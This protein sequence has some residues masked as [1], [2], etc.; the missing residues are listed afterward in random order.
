MLLPG[1]FAPF[2]HVASSVN[3]NF[4]FDTVA[5][6]Y[7]ILSFFGSSRIASSQQF[8]NEIVKRGE[9]FDVTNLIFFG[10][11]NDPKDVEAIPQQDYGRVTFHDLDFAVSKSYGLLNG[12]A[13]ASENGDRAVLSRA[14]FVLDH[15]LRIIGI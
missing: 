1:D 2:F 14:T 8:L 9:R 10:V 12:S 5:G 15:S 4:C 6:R 13:D 7:V 11:T 3:P